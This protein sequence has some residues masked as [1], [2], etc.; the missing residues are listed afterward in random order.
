MS[1]SQIVVMVVL[2]AAS[3]TNAGLLAPFLAHHGRSLLGHRGRTVSG[4]VSLFLAFMCGWVAALA[5]SYPD[6][7]WIIAG[8]AVVFGQG[9]LIILL[10]MLW[11]PGSGD[12]PPVSPDV[13]PGA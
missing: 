11:E 10:A 7:F 13:P 6:Y 4:L 2:A 3:L 5:P 9:A 12:D 8:L 1:G